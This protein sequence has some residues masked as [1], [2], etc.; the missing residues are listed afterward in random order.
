M[1][2]QYEALV[3]AP[4]GVVAIAMQGNQLAIDLLL[5]SPP[6]ENLQFYHPTVIKNSLVQQACEQIQQYLKQA[7]L[8]FNSA[9]YQQQGTAFQ[10]R[11]WQ[12]IAAIPLGQVATYGQIA[13]QIGSGPR[14]VANACGAN[15]IPLIIPCHRVVAKNGI[16]GFMQGKD[17]GLSFKRWLLAHEGVKG[18]SHE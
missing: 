12:A 6:Q 9:L 14:A 2:P 15:H 7:N 5:E 3:D 1:I 10:Q 18:Y 16:G 17:Y 4:F 8:Q 11:V 13:N